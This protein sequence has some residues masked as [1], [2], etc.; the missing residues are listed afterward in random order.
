MTVLD[1]TILT[2]GLARFGI[3]LHDIKLCNAEPSTFTEAVST[4]KIG[5]SPATVSGTTQNRT[6]GGRE[7]V[8]GNVTGITISN[9]GATASHWAWVDMDNSSLSAANSITT[10]KV[11]N[12][13]GGASLSGAS[14]GI[15][16]PG[17]GFLD[18]TVFDNGLVQLAGANVNHIY[19]C[20]QEPTNFTEAS[21][22]YAVGNR[23]SPGGV[24]QAR[25]G[26]GREVAFASNTMTVTT[27]N[28]VVTHKALTR[29]TGSVLLA[30]RALSAPRT[31][32][33]A[34]TPTYSAFAIGIPGAA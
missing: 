27:D 31:V 11:V 5:D 24:E 23:P 17:V 33:T 14:V 34:D 25:A 16:D 32:Y 3:Y 21:S 1:T 9:D 4:Y 10:P 26:G 2:N 22:T 20:T 29:T 30:V 28:Q 6:G 18:D 12:T 8:A 15:P 7:R 19:F 13:A